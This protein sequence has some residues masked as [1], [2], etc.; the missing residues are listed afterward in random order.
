[1]V[2][3]S[4]ILTVSYGTF[5]CTLEGFDESF[6]TMKAIAEYF[7]DLAA[8]DRY[9]GA[10]PPTPDADMLARI[11]ER[12]I[13]RRVE[14]HEHEG[15]IVLRAQDNASAGAARIGALSAAPGAETAPDS[16]PDET[17][18]AE[19]E[20]AP[21][22]EVAAE[23]QPAP[24]GDPVADSADTLESED[25]AETEGP[26][27]DAAALDP[28]QPE[29]LE[30]EDESSAPEMN[31]NETAK[32]LVQQADDAGAAPPV[33][34]TDD[35]SARLDLI[36][37]VVG[38][39]D[40]YDEDE[41]AQDFADTAASEPIAWD[42]VNENDDAVAP[43][44]QETE[45]APPEATEDAASRDE[46]DVSAAETPAPETAAA[47][48]EDSL[49]EDTLAALLADATPV[50]AQAGAATEP[51]TD[52]GETDDATP[53][54]AGDRVSA[55]VLKVSRADVETARAEGLLD[56]SDEVG[57]DTVNIF[58]DEADALSP[59]DEAELQ[60]ELASLDAEIDAEIEAED[61][62]KTWDE[63]EVA[64]GRPAPGPTP[65]VELAH[66]AQ[67]EGG[68]RT[69]VS[70]IFDET[71]SHM[72][73]PGSVRRRNT[74]QHLRAALAATRAERAAGADLEKRIDA[75][76]YRGDLD[77][78]VRPR[79]AM[80]AP[81]APRGTRPEEPRPAPLKLVAEQRVDTARTPVRPR[82]VAAAARSEVVEAQD[83]GFS[84]FAEELGATDLPDLLEAAAAYLA[85]VEGRSQFSRPM[86][87]GKLREIDEEGFSREDGLRSFGQL[88]REGKL[89]KLSGGRFTVTEETE[90]RAAARRRAG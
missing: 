61:E 74:I 77:A 50:D 11:A 15:R 67:A 9:F 87:M 30:R 70:R 41:H 20:I 31:G 80:P 40:T 84:T 71:D 79:R 46:R 52:I 12:E 76:P 83:K 7:R 73:D 38:V 28:L 68:K 51:E 29:G 69:E 81:D 60:R 63:P 27:P 58:G 32:L 23:Q 90:F 33:A 3:S 26:E 62:A 75:S 43:T 1:M 10:E 2:G 8:D 35:L 55:R 49:F 85:D 54:D 14:A 47:R 88:L 82:R 53:P 86:L 5:S 4:K 17:G 16:P 48:D 21:E 6:E 59:E 56:S 25:E 13:A 19:E 37:S 34:G 44:G 42:E 45:A 89:Q 72:A 39:S 64:G 78:A 18:A 24:E 57:E 22:V 66:A 65:E 36:R